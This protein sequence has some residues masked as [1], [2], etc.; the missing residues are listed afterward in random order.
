MFGR[1]RGGLHLCALGGAAAVLCP[2]IVGR[3]AGGPPVAVMV[4][5]RWRDDA[6][7]TPFYGRARGGP[8]GRTT[9]EGGRREE[10]KGPT[11]IM[12]KRGGGG[13]ANGVF[14][15][16]WN[17]GMA[18]GGSGGNIPRFK[19]KGRAKGC[20]WPVEP[21]PRSQPSPAIACGM[22]DRFWVRITS[23][24]TRRWCNRRSRNWKSR[25]RKK[26]EK[27]NI[28]FKPSSN[29]SD[30]RSLQCL[31]LLQNQWLGDLDSNQD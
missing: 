29:R 21:R 20:F 2:G 30:C 31:K 27:V 3:A 28:F 8:G 22:S 18:A 13:W 15:A 16:C 17:T 24:E 19:G 14:D 10:K 6:P 23:A 7:H 4:G 12:M 11:I 9:V 1:E 26:S 5:R 25:G